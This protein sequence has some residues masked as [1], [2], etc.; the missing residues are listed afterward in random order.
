MP[1]T[2]SQ[3]LYRLLPKNGKQARGPPD[4]RIT[5]L[6]I[7][8]DDMLMMIMKRMLMMMTAGGG[9]RRECRQEEGEP[10]AKGGVPLS[11]VIV[12]P[13]KRKRN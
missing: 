6:I 10:R 9:Q 4:F 8:M 2:Q 5:I 11:F 1:K 13:E 3:K 7:I 12:I